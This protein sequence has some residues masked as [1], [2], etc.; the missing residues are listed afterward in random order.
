ML[1]ADHHINW[2][3]NGGIPM[4][5]TWVDNVSEEPDAHVGEESDAQRTVILWVGEGSLGVQQ[6]GGNT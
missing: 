2:L 3:I 6:N 1:I 5:K 4:P